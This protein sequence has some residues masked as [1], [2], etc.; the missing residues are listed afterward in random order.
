MLS[1]FFKFEAKKASCAQDE[2]HR[3]GNLLLRDQVIKTVYDQEQKNAFRCQTKQAIG[4]VPI[5]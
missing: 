3:K 5:N 1:H 2:T 4:H